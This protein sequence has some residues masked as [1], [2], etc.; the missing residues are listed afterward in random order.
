MNAFF[1]F[2]ILNIF[3]RIN[4]FK[5]LQISNETCALSDLKIW[6][7]ISLPF[8]IPSKPKKAIV[9][10]WRFIFC[11][12]I[13]QKYIFYKL[14][15]FNYFNNLYKIYISSGRQWALILLS[16]PIFWYQMCNR[17]SLGVKTTIS[18]KLQKLKVKW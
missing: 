11:V 18:S 5:A 9:L 2:D 7:I 10:N 4:I 17:Q 16:K 14:F 12:N 13:S 8:K 3:K 1:R 15:Y 6:S